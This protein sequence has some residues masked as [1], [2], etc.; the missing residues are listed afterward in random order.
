MLPSVSSADCYCACINN[1]KTK[2]CE[3]SWDANY[4]YCDGTYCT[5]GLDLPEESPMDSNS[6]EKLLALVNI[7]AKPMSVIRK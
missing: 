1:K 6:K 2:V 3:N 5:G 4:V 7:E